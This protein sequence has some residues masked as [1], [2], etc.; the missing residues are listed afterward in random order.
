MVPEGRCRPPWQLTPQHNLALS[1]QG[2]TQNIEDTSLVICATK[3][4]NE[5]YRQDKFLRMMLDL[6]WCL[7]L[8]IHPLHW[9]YWLF[10]TFAKH[11]N[12]Q[13]HVQLNLRY[14]FTSCVICVGYF[15]QIRWVPA[16]LSSIHDSIYGHTYEQAQ[17]KNKTGRTK[18]GPRLN[19]KTVLS[20]YGDFHVKDKTAVRTSYL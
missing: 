11:S 1:S 2:D 3:V 4:E 7:T 5:I 18:S 12:L 13:F 15:K 8:W 14:I 17:R 6:G 20:T 9:Q 16:K 19:I 10:Q